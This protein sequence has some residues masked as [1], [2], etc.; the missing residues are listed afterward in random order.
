LTP[1]RSLPH[2][3]NLHFATDTFPGYAGDMRM[4]RRVDHYD[5]DYDRRYAEKK[6]HGRVELDGDYM[7]WEPPL[8]LH[9]RQ[10]NPNNPFC[11]SNNTRSSMDPM[12]QLAD[13]DEAELKWFRENWFKMD[14]IDPAKWA[15]FEGDVVLVT[16]KLHPDYLRFGRISRT[17]IPHGYIWVQGLNSSEPVHTNE[18]ER[19]N[20]KYTSFLKPFNYR[21]VKYLKYGNALL[22]FLGHQKKGFA[23]IIGDDDSLEDKENFLDV[24]FRNYVSIELDENN[25]VE[26]DLDAILS[27]RDNLTNVLGKAGLLETLDLEMLYNDEFKPETFHTKTWQQLNAVRR[28]YHTKDPVELP[29]K[30][31]DDNGLRRTD[32]ID[33]DIMMTG[34]DFRDLIHTQEELG[35]FDHPLAEHFMA[36]HPL[37][38]EETLGKHF[39]ISREYTHG[40][41]RYRNET[42]KYCPTSSN[43]RVL[44]HLEDPY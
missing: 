8:A 10:W 1:P 7:A 34:D 18:Q 20:K 13:V 30:L 44:S 14:L 9:K 17:Y 21:D 29:D 40:G 12:E 15:L 35:G 33:D 38:W 6:S 25:N 24:P 2:A 4:M 3:P 22:D 36:I 41:Y 42:D 39:N 27:G 19:M 37:T 23:A 5:T 31:T 32:V 28:D 16:N 26:I 11:P 43:R